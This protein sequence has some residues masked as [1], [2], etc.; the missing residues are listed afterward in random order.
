[1]QVAGAAHNPF[2]KSALRAL[3]QRSHGVPRLINIIADRALVGAYAGEARDINAALIHAA[4]DEVQLGE[5]G[6][7]RGR[8]RWP[9]AAAAGLIL[10]LIAWSTMRSNGPEL[11]D[12]APAALP[13]IAEVVEESS[14]P[15]K[16]MPATPPVMSVTRQQSMIDPDWL[17]IQSQAAWGGLALLW[18]EPDGGAEIELACQGQLTRNWA[19]LKADG[20]LAR[21]KQLGLPVVLLLQGSDPGLLLLQGVDGNRLLAGAPGTTLTLSR[22]AVED[23]WFG[24]YMVAWPQASGWPK[25]IEKGDRGPAVDTVLRL[26]SMAENP[27]SGRQVFGDEFER[28]LVNFQLAYGL[29][30]DGIVG[31]KTLL[32]LMRPSISRPALIFNWQEEN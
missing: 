30:S 8:W 27:Y 17:A 19:C 22:D 10:A 3:Y 1:M 14:P 23:K 4:A 18:D 2:R 15:K 6:A 29:D 28:W 7:R 5:P 26:A 25:E 12:S 11:E 13:P 24:A 32:Y 9:L 20:S 16:E 21:I 31:P